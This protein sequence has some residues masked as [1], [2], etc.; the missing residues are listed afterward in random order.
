MWTP[1]QRSPQRSTGLVDFRR[2]MSEAQP[3]QPTSDQDNA[4]EAKKAEKP[5]GMIPSARE[6]SKAVEWSNS[7]TTSK[8]REIE[9]ALN[10]PCIQKMKEGS[11]G[12][13]FI[14]AYRCFLESETEPKGSDCVEYFSSMQK[15]MVEHPEEYDLDSDSDDSEDFDLG[16]EEETGH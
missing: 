15:C 4:S 2:G 1:E 10:C 11:C 13:Q 3:K 7:E 12:E 5:A 8:E 16:D 14:A 9:E 6:D